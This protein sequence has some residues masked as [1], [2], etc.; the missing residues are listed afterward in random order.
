MWWLLLFFLINAFFS[1]RYAGLD[2]DPD[3]AYFNLAGQVG[4]WYGRD[5][6]DCKSPLV[7]IWFWILSKIWHP[8]YGVRFLHFFITGI[9]AFVYTFLTGD[10]WGGLAFIILVHSGWLYAFHGN[11]GDVPAGLIL[12]ALIVPNPWIAVGLFVLAV[13]YEPKLIVSLALYVAIG[14]FWWQSVAFALAGGVSALALWYFKHEWWRW[15]IEANLTIPK[16]MNKA[17][18]GLYD[19]MPGYTSMCFLYAGMWVA[20][21]VIARPD[22][23]YWLPVIAYMLLM[24][25]GR[26]IRPNHLLP[27]VAWIAVAGI[28]PVWVIAFS[29]VDFIS[30]GLYL[31]DI[32]ARFY[33]GLRD[34]IKDA[35][36]LGLWLKDKPG[37]LWL[38]SM[39]TEIYIWSSKQPLYGMTEQIEIAQVADERRKKML[40]QFAKEPPD[41]VIDQPGSPAQFDKHGFKLVAQSGFFNVYERIKT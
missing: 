8:V 3:F 33:L 17:R 24:F 2:I 12:I 30:S 11:V 19:Y 13:L 28:E 32:W 4:S 40:M 38:N 25:A 36:E 21:A 26:V 15:L 37:R 34:R 1:W 7:H 41:W 29:S 23:L 22:I 5:Y 27:I 6:V 20:G 9:P 35:R 39:H 18:K 14:G 31:G 10:I 16:R